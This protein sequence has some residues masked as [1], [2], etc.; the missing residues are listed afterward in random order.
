MTTDMEIAEFTVQRAERQAAP[1][2]IGLSGRSGAGKTLSALRMARG[3]VGPDGKIVLIDTEGKRSL[4][5]ADDAEVAGWDHIDFRPPYSSERFQAAVMAASNAGAEVIIIDSAS[6]EHEA[7]GGMLDF[8]DREEKRM[9]GS[10]AA[11]R[12]KWIKPKAAH[13]RF[14]RATK[15]IPAHVIF[16]IRMKRIV[17]MESKPPKWIELPVCDG[18][19]LYD[20]DIM[21]ELGADDHAAQFRRVPLPFHQHIRPGEKL[22]VDHGKLLMQEAGVGKKL[23][24]VIEDL[25]SD[26]NAVA[27]LG[28]AKLQAEWGKM[29]KE[30]PPH[31]REE[32]RKDLENWKQIAADADSEA[33]EPEEGEVP[34]GFEAQ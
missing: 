27:T 14:I 28:M 10:R 31:I 11:S 2:T 12:N 16:C 1:L 6:H 3:M 26:L 23:D 29:W 9:S 5:Y 25:R 17:D 22:T 24:P 18:N 13:N 20:M 32:L 33:R 4:I 7:E 15:S 21:I 30:Q 8:A 19:L 34:K